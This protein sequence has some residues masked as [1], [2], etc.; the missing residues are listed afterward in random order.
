MTRKPTHSW[1]NSAGEVWTPVSKEEAAGKKPMRYYNI[2]SNPGFIDETFT[3]RMKFLDGLN[4]KIAPDF[5]T[6]WNKE[7][8]EL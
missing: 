8:T 2:D 7:K 5:V 3:D 4:E 1:G 6:E